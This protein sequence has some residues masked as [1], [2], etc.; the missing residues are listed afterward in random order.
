M[1][2]PLTES[3]WSQELGQGES[4]WTPCLSFPRGTCP[5]KNDRLASHLPSSS[6][7]QA[8]NS[9][10]AQANESQRET[11]ERCLDE[12]GGLM[13]PVRSTACRLQAPGRDSLI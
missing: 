6:S 1:C 12:V 7:L 3:P 9:A 5:G 10:L 11:Y 13:P 4:Y 8:E 2:S